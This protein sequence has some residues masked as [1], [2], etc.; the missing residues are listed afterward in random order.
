MTAD[1]T[2][3]SDYGDGVE[4]EGAS[5]RHPQEATSQPWISRIAIAVCVVVFLGLN[6]EARLDS[7]ATLTK[8]GCLPATSIRNGAIWGLITCAFVHMALWH[9]AFNMYWLWVLGSRMERAIGSSRFLAFVLM[10]AFVS[11]SVQLAVSDQTGI[12]ASGFVYGIFGF[13]WV[14][15]DRYPTF[16][17]VL[18]QQTINVFVIW[19]FGCLA[20]TYLKI[21]DVGNAAHFSGII[22][23]AA[24]ANYFIVGYRRTGTLAGLAGM[25]LFCIISLFWCPWSVTWLSQKAYAAHVAA[26]YDRARDLY[27]RIIQIDPK[28]AWAYQNRSAVFDSLGKDEEARHDLEAARKIDPSIS[29]SEANGADSQ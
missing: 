19:L 3:T 10:T 11:S 14:A 25:V 1:I 22:F 2:P 21:W 17:E 7:W 24:V 5:S 27:S 23:G 9:V 6:A 20:A 18:N 13:M 12:G 8:W 29:N 15:R 4:I 16:N 26:Q 28:N